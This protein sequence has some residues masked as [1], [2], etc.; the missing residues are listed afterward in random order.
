MFRVAALWLLTRLCGCTH[1]PPD[2]DARAA[3]ADAIATTA[4]WQGLRLSTGLF[5][6]AA[7]ASHPVTDTPD[8]LTVYLEGDGLAWLNP[9]TASQD[10]TPL[11]PLALKLAVRDP[12]RSV[13][14][15]ARPCQYTVKD[16]PQVC[17]IKW[18]T[19]HRFA[20]EVIAAS[21]AAIDQLKRRVNAHHI[22]LVGYSGGGAV[23][24][25]IAA[26]R[27]DVI[28]LTTVAGNLDHG[29]WTRWHALTPLS[30][31]L[32]AADVAS[33]LTGIA[34]THWVGGR[35]T[36]VGRRLADAFA[37]RTPGASRLRINVLTEADHSCCW[38][39]HWPLDP[40]G[41]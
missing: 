36:V 24:A 19:S 15:L 6:L 37:A 35:D 7:Y 32:N 1:G 3:A 29:L 21:T 28:H 9:S 18:W 31:S 16:Q 23:A 5:V 33:S 41:H 8:V 2:A 4:Q 38:D 27:A 39:Q 13:A 11:N 14:W 40:D 34:Q 22:A 25:L 30:G 26:R 20:E 12:G 17:S 10:P